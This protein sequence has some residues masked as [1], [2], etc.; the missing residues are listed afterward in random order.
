MQIIKP[1][2]QK[3]MSL[4]MLGKTHD[5]IAW[6]AEMPIDKVRDILNEPSIRSMMDYIEISNLSNSL[7]KSRLKGANGM[8]DQLISGA[9][10]ILNDVDPIK[11]NKNHVSLFMMLMKEQEKLNKQMLDEIQSR[12]N[13]TNNTQINVYTN[14]QW[15]EQVLAKLPAKAQESFWQ[16]I[17]ELGQ[18]YADEYT[19]AWYIDGEVTEVPESMR[20]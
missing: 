8:I 17:I 12:I 9:Q 7:V 1:E 2:Q 20:D 13:I 3:V 5:Q 14:T 11:W 19:R 10:K 16:E 4:A 6:L 15:L 18:K